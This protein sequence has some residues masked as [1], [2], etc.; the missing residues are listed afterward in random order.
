MG[1]LGGEKNPVTGRGSVLDKVL[2]LSFTN[3]ATSPDLLITRGTMFSDL[4]Q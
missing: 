1:I 2:H 3:K 4:K